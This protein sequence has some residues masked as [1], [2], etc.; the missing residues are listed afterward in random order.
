MEYVFL[1][2]FFAS[3]IIHLWARLKQKPRVRNISKVFILLPLL[4]FYIFSAKS[5]NVFVCLALGACWIGDLLLLMRSFKWF[6]LGGLSFGIGH[7]FFI[8]SYIQDTSFASINLFLMIAIIVAAIIALVIIIVKLYPFLKKKLVVPAS[9]YLSANASMNV[10]AILHFVSKIG[11]NLPYL[12]SLITVIG[13]L[14]FFVS[15]TALF[16]VRF[17][18]N[19]IMRTHFLVMLTYSL[20]EFL[21][22]LGLIML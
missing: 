9:I 17:N 22:V 15:D 10:F 6:A 1:A 18:K 11:A 5:I 12:A 20:G 2:I 19:S 7:V 13:A 8:I 3:T 16:F 4:L 14:L 21:I